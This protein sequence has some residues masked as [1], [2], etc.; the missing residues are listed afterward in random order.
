MSPYH[1]VSPVMEPVTCL[2]LGGTLIAVPSFFD[3]SRYCC[4]QLFYPVGFGIMNKINSYHF[5]LAV[6][7][8]YHLTCP[9]F[10][11]LVQ[12]QDVCCDHQEPPSEVNLV[13]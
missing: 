8:G 1:M 4:I 11:R 13:L 7:M 9:R 10:L 6:C 2:M 5:A 12:Y 3:Y